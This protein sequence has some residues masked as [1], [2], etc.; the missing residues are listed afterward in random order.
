MNDRIQRLNRQMAM[1]DA[2]GQVQR[3][4]RIAYTVLFARGRVY[5]ETHHQA[6]TPLWQGQNFTIG[7][8][9]LNII[10]FQHGFVTVVRHD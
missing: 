1:V 2:I 8:H 6:H 10:G 7:E 9:A 4:R 3:Y 5:D